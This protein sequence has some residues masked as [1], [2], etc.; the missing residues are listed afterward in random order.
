MIADV[1]ALPSAPSCP[2]PCSNHCGETSDTTPLHGRT[3]L[4]ARCLVVRMQRALVRLSCLAIP[5]APE[6]QE[7]CLL[8]EEL[9]VIEAR[10]A[11][12]GS[13]S[14]NLMARRW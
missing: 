3:G 10:R 5:S 11:N 1:I 12:T 8:L 2:T 13:A 4:C 6:L 9:L 7:D 14:T